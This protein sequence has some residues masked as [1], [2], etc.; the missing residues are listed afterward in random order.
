LEN[1]VVFQV[2]SLEVV[3]WAATP[4]SQLPWRGLFS[5][6]SSFLFHVVCILNVVCDILLV[7]GL[8]IYDINMSSM[9]KK[10]LR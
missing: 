10:Y 1:I 8:D 9:L 2:L 6:S 4:R 3:C 7:H 5:F